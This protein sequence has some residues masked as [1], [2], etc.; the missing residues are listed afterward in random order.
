MIRVRWPANLLGAEADLIAAQQALEDLLEGA[1]EQQISQAAMALAQARDNVRVAEYKWNNQQEGRR[2]STDTVRGAEARLTLAQVDVDRAD[3]EY[4]SVSGRPSDDPAKALA[5]TKLVAARAD[6]D[7]ALRNVN[8]YT[9]HPTEIQQA[10]LDSEVAVAQAGLLQ[11]EQDLADLRAGPDADAVK[12]AEARLRAAQAVVDQSRLVSPIDGTVL[13]VRHGVGDSVVPGE[14]ELVIADLSSLHI[15]TSVD[16]LDVGDV[17]IGQEVEITLDALP[18]L[19][20]KGSVAGI[21]L[22]PEVGSTNTQYPVRVELE[23]VDDLVRVGMTAALSIL[24]ADEDGVVLVPNWALGFDTESG[25]IFVFVVVG[26][27]REPRPLV[28]GLRN[29]TVSEV[30]SGLE[31]GETIGASIEERSRG[32]GGFFFGGG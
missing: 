27:A 32:N 4:S 1:S 5:L 30:V 3:D 28:L 12:S 10:I 23:S 25:G 31:A 8:W 20:L 16:E 19:V 2:A 11:A 9:G 18:N 24:V 17:V 22:S 26:D 29:D 6:R 7:S 13:S 15:D 21:D 14:V